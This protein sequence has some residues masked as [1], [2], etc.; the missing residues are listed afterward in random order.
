MCIIAVCKS[1]KLTAEEISYCFSRNSHGAG[2]AYR[3]RGKVVVV[4]GLM[5]EED[6]IAEYSA[7]KTFPHVVHFRLASAGGVCR[8][9]THPF[10]ITPEAS[11]ALDYVTK[12]DVLFHNGSVSGWKDALLAMVPALVMQG[13]KLPDGPWSDTRAVALMA[14]LAGLGVIELMY[15]KFV[16]FG[17]VRCALYGDFTEDRG[18]WF[19]NEGYKSVLAASPQNKYSYYGYVDPYSWDDGYDWET[20]SGVP[21]ERRWVRRYIAKPKSDKER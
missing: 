6:L 14:S 11:V 21:A 18:V 16:V 13:K 20:E 9:L 1:R 8:E 12:D 19:S 5:K 10:P 15:G 17:P 4:K 7:V 3:H 2:I